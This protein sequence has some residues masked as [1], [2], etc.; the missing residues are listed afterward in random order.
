MSAQIAAPASPSDYDRTV[1]VIMAAFVSDPFLRWLF[2]DAKQYFDHAPQVL[3]HHGGAAFDHGWAYRTADYGGGALWLPPGVGPDEEALGAVVE[4]SVAAERLEDLFA[5]FEQIGAAHPEDE[6][7]FLPAIGV[8]PPLQGQG[9]GAALM[10]RGLEASDA[11]HVATYLESSNPTNIPFY[12][13]FGFEVIAELQS[14]GSPV[15]TAMLR[16]AR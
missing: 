14:G 7:W 13:R 2:P 6:H 3:R 1:A 9:H 16:P 8:D 15:I 10:A 5:L 4:A 11:A 12:R